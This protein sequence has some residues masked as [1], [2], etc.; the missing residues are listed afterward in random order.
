MFSIKNPIYTS[1]G[2]YNMCCSKYK[3]SVKLFLTEEKES[4]I[5]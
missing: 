5:G 3:K 1:K 2:K 4:R